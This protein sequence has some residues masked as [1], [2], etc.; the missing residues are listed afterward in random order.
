[1]DAAVE[2][3]KPRPL[4][5]VVNSTLFLPLPL[6]ALLCSVF[7]QLPRD[8]FWRIVEMLFT[9]CC[10]ERSDHFNCPLDW[11]WWHA[12]FEEE[13]EE[14]EKNSYYL[15]THWC[16]MFSCLFLFSASERFDFVT[17]N[18]WKKWLLRNQNSKAQISPLK[19]TLWAATSLCWT[20]CSRWQH[21]HSVMP[22]NGDGTWNIGSLVTAK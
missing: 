14:E 9:C 12:S 21:S 5:L 11:P 13:E 7:L 1:M 16:A 3:T 15:K 19:D 6:G 20:R 4:V 18:F 2:I 10:K 17:F 8:L 22:E